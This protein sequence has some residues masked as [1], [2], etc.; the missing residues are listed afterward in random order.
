MTSNYGRVRIIEFVSST[1]VKGFCEIGLFDT[2]EIASGGWELE[3]GYEAAW[4][5]SRGYPVSITFHEGRLYFAG[6][7]SLPTTFWGSV[8]TNFF[9]FELGEG[10]DD[11]SISATITTASLNEIVDIFSGRDLQIFTTGA[12]FISRS[13]SA[14]R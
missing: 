2:A 5:G 7:K 13:P 3:A 10:L 8:V 14:S 1:V 4:S 12:N 6:S 9:D 11:Q